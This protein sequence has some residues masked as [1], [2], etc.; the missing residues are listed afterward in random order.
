MKRHIVSA[1]L[2]AMLATATIGT[3][4][5]NAQVSFGIQVGPPPAP[6]VYHSLPRKPG[7]DYVWIE[8]Y[9]YPDVHGK[10]YKW[11]SGYWTRPPFDGAIWVAPRYDGQRFFEG[12]WEN[13]DRRMNHDHR[14]DHDRDRDYRR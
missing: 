6:R 10:S 3:L 4:P 8:G 1:L 12:Y 13:S 11:H 7:P 9:W 5:L 2:S 14:W